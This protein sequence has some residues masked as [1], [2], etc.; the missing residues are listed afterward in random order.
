MESTSK[1]KVTKPKNSAP[2]PNQIKRKHWYDPPAY[3]IK[4]SKALLKTRAKWLLLNALIE[5][6]EN[7]SITE[8][9]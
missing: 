2:T 3:P 9:T 1:S 4:P 6:A 8:T 7:N 5:I